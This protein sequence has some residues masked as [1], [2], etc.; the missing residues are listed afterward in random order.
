MSHAAA[1]CLFAQLARESCCWRTALERNGKPLGLRSLLWWWFG[2][3][4]ELRESLMTTWGLYLTILRCIQEQ[5]SGPWFY[6]KLSEW[7]YVAILRIECQYTVY[8]HT[9]ALHQI[10]QGNPCQSLLPKHFYLRWWNWSATIQ[11]KQR[12]D[13]KIC[14]HMAAKTHT[15]GPTRPVEVC[16]LTC[17]VRF[18]VL[19]T[20]Q[21]A[22]PY[23]W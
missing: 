19:C 14:L 10:T 7:H 8:V 16:S 9:Q 15:L 22:Q 5:Y 12:A 6:F 13:V 20:S 3:S 23:H 17:Q 11:N 21:N 2:G 18:L 1:E 4:W